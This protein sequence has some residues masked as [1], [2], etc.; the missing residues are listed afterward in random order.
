MPVNLS[1]LEAAFSEALEIA[2]GPDRE[3]YLDRACGA[4]DELRR[5]V[6]SML[7]VHDRAGR[8][9]ESPTVSFQPGPLEPVGSTIGPY[10][11]LEEIGEG[12][13]G[14]VYM[15]EQTHPVR[16]KVAVKIIKPGMDSRQVVARFEAERQALALM[17]HPNIARVLDADATESGRPY[18]V[19]ELVRGVPI[20]DY[21]DRANL[22]IRE[23][24]ELF[25]LVCRAVQH[26]HQK[27]IIHRDIKPS[28][29]LITLHDGVPVP[30]VIDFGIAKA[31]GLSLT[32]KT[33]FTGFT[34]LIGTPLYMSPEQAEL[35]GIDVDTRSDIYSLGV[36]L[37]ELLSGT[38]PFDPETL[39]T[40]AL[41]EV[42]RII[43]EQDPPTPSNR[44]SALGDTQ[45]TVSA[46]RGTDPRKLGRSLRGELD[47]IVM[48]ALEKD[49]R[50][51]YETASAFAADI[52]RYRDSQPIEARPAS[53]L[54][55]ARKFA[56]RNRAAITTTAVAS[57]ALIVGTSL[58]VWQAARAQIARAEALTQ[59][60]RARKAVDEMYTQVADKWLSEQ[61]QLEPLQREFLLKAL[62]FYQDFAKKPGLDSEARHAA[63]IAERRAGQIHRKLGENS[64]SE[65]AYRR[66][67]E[68]LEQVSG[69]L[70]DAPNIRYEHSVISDNLGD[71]LFRVGR[72]NESEKAY[73]RAIQIA[74][75]LVTEFPDD[76]QYREGF[77]ATRI[78]FVRLLFT[79]DRMAEARQ[80]V[81]RI[82]LSLEALVLKYPNVPVFRMHLAQN[83]VHYAAIQLEVGR[84]I[85][86]ERADRR[87]IELW[88]ALLAD[89]PKSTVV[90]QQLA[91]SYN[92]LGVCLT[93]SGRSPEAVPVQRRA[94]ELVE[95]L[96]SEFPR[97]V[98]YRALRAESYCN[99]GTS[100]SDSGQLADAA[101]TL[102]RAVD[103]FETLVADFSTAP[104]YRTMLAFSYY[105]LGRVHGSTNALAEAE[106]ALRRALEIDT[107]LAVEWPKVG[108]YQH[109]VGDEY[110]ILAALHFVQG[111]S[112]EGNSLMRRAIEHSAAAVRANPEN[113]RYRAQLRRLWRMHAQ[114]LAQLGDHSGSVRAVV[115]G[116]AASGSGYSDLPFAIG[117]VAQCRRIAATDSRLSPSERV[118][119][120]RDYGERAAALVNKAL[121]AQQDDA[122]FLN[123]LAWLLA[124]CTERELRDPVQAVALA[125]KAL[126]HAPKLG[127]IWNT[128]GVA[129]YRAGSSD[130]AIKALERSM[131]LTN[132]GAPADWLFMAMARW[133]LGE[134]YAA[135]SWFD[136]AVVWMDAQKPVD[137]ESQRFRAEAAALLNR[138]GPMPNGIA[139][140]AR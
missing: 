55:R 107:R 27:G 84:Y 21:C 73:R 31:T 83:C 9:L 56:R 140:F 69:K 115:D 64:A 110:G 80:L 70:A 44:L 24:L 38:T 13:M 133:Q 37:Y 108:D 3:A 139:A 102:R 57:T 49:R 32:D 109:K 43:R 103:L 114:I 2:A 96:A 89:S 132:G 121:S 100:L 72:I 22:P 81:R 99:L 65:Q 118:A 53:S 85:E 66:G 1:S 61:A 137:E 25:A 71:L 59:R 82:E 126:Q 29:V 46:N 91:Q 93:Q 47:W 51:R 8:F 68:L 130:E 135:C 106:R 11:L 129:Q 50:R 120:E 40:V 75:N 104:H 67:L 122:E 138:I 101:H 134:N 74:E 119:K 20:T 17:D 98:D 76:P 97:V 41:D 77:E 90:R 28:N 42:R 105:S 62:A 52:E 79:T 123:E 16:R 36:L 58:S 128:L 39:R 95:S 86:A 10:K 45:T 48:K 117:I 14:I 94:L 125:K 111:D 113:G 88:E 26:A 60:D 30:K 23:R 12:G 7:D 4:D 6:Q 124:T 87:A 54:Y 5:K 116:L 15:A 33:L 35:S 78:S 136:K 34:Q 92:A 131:E 63:A 127:A 19:M 18:F 112:S